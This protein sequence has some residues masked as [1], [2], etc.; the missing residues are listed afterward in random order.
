MDYIN[1][2]EK[3]VKIAKKKNI[4]IAT[5]ESCT[6]GL[7]SSAITS[8]S[9]SSTIFGYGYITYANSAKIKLLGV[10]SQ[11]LDKF[12]AVS[13]E[14]VIEM[15]LGA[16][17]DSGADFGIAVTGIAGPTGGTSEK[18]V[19]TV[20]IAVADGKRNCCVNEYQ[21]DGDRQGIRIQ[22]ACAA[23]ELCIVHIQE[24]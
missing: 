9:G 6:G 18:P 15:A 11:T 17:Y 22:A 21:F 23:L 2:A 13:S 7:I 8:T 1:L 5:A 24:H 4:K 12:G 19:G 16:M 20:F 3:L 10:K 14:T